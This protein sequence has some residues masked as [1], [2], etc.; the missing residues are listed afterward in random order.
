MTGP[1]APAR[2]RNAADSRQA[3]LAAAQELFAERGFERSTIRDI[4][5]RAG[6]DPTLIARYF[7]NKASL[8]LAAL[9]S[10]FDAEDDAVRDLLQPE[11]MI[12][13]LD[14]VG[15][16]GP[17]PVFGTALRQHPDPAVDAEARAVLTERIVDPLQARIDAHR[18]DARAAADTRLRAEI[19]AA[20][21]IGV[22]VSRHVGA[23]PALSAASTGQ[24]SE[25]LAR[26]LGALAP[27]SP[28]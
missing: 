10:D 24:V 2:R 3:L 1:K 20:A 23:F 12:E 21:F 11:R 9:R 5:D 26:T 22:A 4:G 8:Y 13:L 28:D 18:D 17:S 27:G 7:G 16:K 14:R 25:L 15:R 19:I 6:L